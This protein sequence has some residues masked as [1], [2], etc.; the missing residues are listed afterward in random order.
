MSRF[1]LPLLA[2]ELTELAA[3]RRTY[4]IRA[5][6]AILLSVISWMAFQMAMLNR[7]LSPLEM[8]GT[9][10]II[11]TWIAYLQNM[12]LLLVLPALSCDV[13]TKEKERQTI[14]LLLVTRLSHGKIV[15]EKFFSR[16][17]PALCLILISMPLLALSYALGGVEFE[18]I[19]NV[20]LGLFCNAIVL[21]S[22][23]VACSSFCQT[24]TAA[25]IWTYVI[26][27]FAPLRVISLSTSAI[28]YDFVILG[29][30][31]SQ[32]V[33]QNSSRTFGMNSSFLSGVSRASMIGETI[34]L[35]VGLMVPALVASRFFLAVA[36][37]YLFRCAFRTPR[38]PKSWFRLLWRKRSSVVFNELLAS[39]NSVRG[40]TDDPGLEFPI[41]WRET[42]HCWWYTRLG[43]TIVVVGLI[44]LIQFT[45]FLSSRNDPTGGRSHFTSYTT[46]N[47]GL[48]VGTLLVLTTQASGLIALER[49]QQTLEV[50]LTAPLTGAEILRQKLAA[51]RIV[52][53]CCLVPLL[54]CLIARNIFEM[55]QVYN[56]TRGKEPYY[57]GLLN[58][59][60]MLVIYPQ[61]A[62][63]LAVLFSLKSQSALAAITKSLL[64]IVLA[65]LI[66]WGILMLFAIAAGGFSTWAF[67]MITA[68]LM[69]SPADL[70]LYGYGFECIPPG[71][72][73]SFFPVILNSVVHGGTWWALR[74]YCLSNADQLLGRNPCRTVGPSIS[75][76]EATA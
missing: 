8:L 33:L 11:L 66:P 29:D 16:V 2:K 57:L 1:G 54:F 3:R 69:F 55:P 67:G 60:T 28:P 70:L 24:S 9:G 32:S 71:F 44:G 26:I 68:L 39:S 74:R 65:C 35:Q 15:W 18:S 63:W 49:R 72:S 34:G 56:Q 14:G 5:A 23:S 30:Y 6:Y 13:F 42:Q 58:E 64:S 46:W 45:V 4:L 7:S 50:L 59:L 53:T 38:S 52:L 21:V 36:K 41:A 20:G 22:I 76:L 12:G 62:I 43:Q 10:R 27:C 40:R 73:E 61:L 25:F 31:L 75:P 48:W 37:R 17:I 51:T 19:L 47:L